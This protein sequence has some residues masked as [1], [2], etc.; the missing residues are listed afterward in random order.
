[1]VVPFFDLK[2]QYAALE[3]EILSAIADFLP[4]QQLILGETVENFERHLSRYCH[5]PHAIGVSSGTDALALALES[6]EIQAGDEVI[7]PAFTYFATAS[8]VVRRGAKPVFCDIDPLTYNLNPHLLESLLTSRTKAI[9]PV[10][11]FGHAAPMP[12]ILAWAMR[13][14]VE[15]IE[16]AAQAIGA[17]IHGA[18][19]GSFG[20]MAAFSFYPTKNLG[21]FGDAGALT[22][23]RDEDAIRLRM[24]RAQGSKERYVHEG[25]G[26]AFRLDALQALILSIK[27]PHLESW[28]EARQQHARYYL[29]HLSDIEGL[30]LPV[31]LDGYRHTYNQFVIRT[32]QRDALRAHLQNMGIYTE[33]YYPR[34]LPDQPIFVQLGYHKCSCP[35]ARAAAREVLALP[36]YPELTEEALQKVVHAIRLFFNK[37]G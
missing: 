29:H 36:I 6:L 19:V 22:A 27:L 30:S 10:H 5:T 25:I 34:A 2:A 7:V 24:L 8:V 20:R 17:E 13:H 1:M 37:N 4:K 21:A 32:K 12:E 9:I 11:L 31:T 18:R 15:V 33:I 23:H 35:E 3:K 26:G 28:H 16:D 14:N